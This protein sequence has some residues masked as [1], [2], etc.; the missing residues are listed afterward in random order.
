MPCTG[1][2]IVDEVRYRAIQVDDAE[3][4]YD[5]ARA[6]WHHTYREIFDED[7]IEAFVRRNY[8]PAVI[9]ETLPGV[10]AGREFFHVAEL[11]GRLVGFCHIG[12]HPHGAQL[13][14]I[15]LAPDMI[16]RGIGSGLLD[17]GE[18]YLQRRGRRHYHC[19]VHRD[20]ALGRR[21]YERRGFEHIASRDHED[22]WYM[23]KRLDG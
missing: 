8:A 11:E 3:P 22:E 13:F 20:N 4:L 21:F 1:R 12:L 2:T 14:R 23:E 16:G 17:L 15:Y 6:A 9:E 18:A 19:Y 10:D 7:F 5:L